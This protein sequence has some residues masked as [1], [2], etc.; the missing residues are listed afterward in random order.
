VHLRDAATNKM[1]DH[2]RKGNV[3]FNWLLDAL[4]ERGYAG[5]VSIECLPGSDPAV[6][7]DDILRL[8]AIAEERLP[9]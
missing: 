5:H 8:K 4:K 1:Y 7:R 2:T 3:D 9:G 6:L